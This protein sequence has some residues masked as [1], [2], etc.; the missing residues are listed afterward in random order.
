MNAP[1]R[2]K[3]RLVRLFQVGLLALMAYGI[4]RGNVG[5]AVNGGISL[6]V[7]FVL[8]F[9]RRDRVGSVSA[10]FALWLT[11]TVFVHAV[12]IL[13]PYRQYPWYDSVAHALSA[14]IVAGTSYAFLRAVELHS[15]RVELPRKLRFAFVLV[16]ALVFGVLWEVLEFTSGI[17]A[18][19]ISS[20]AVFIQFGVRDIILDLVFNF[21]GGVIVLAWSRARPMRVTWS[22]TASM[23]NDEQQR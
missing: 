22:L 20:K 12:G 18:K 15:D 23:R 13:G 9:L 7:T 11:T 10:G 17:L 16:F 2:Y 3:R 4:Y 19:A 8:A 21:V 6:F 14:S 1:E 5:N